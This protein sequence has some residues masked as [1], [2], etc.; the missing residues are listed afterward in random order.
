MV[1]AGPIAMV[2]VVVVAVSL[3]LTWA[4]WPSTGTPALIADAIVIEK[5]ARRLSLMREDKAIKSYRIAL[6][7]APVGANERE[8]DRKTPEG[9]YRITEHFERSAFHRALRL[10]YPEP[11]DV[12]RARTLKVSPG[13]TS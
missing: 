9:I 2:A 12:L 11:K 7:R 10:S 5:E 6:G 13:R 4:N 3:L 1:K 8:G